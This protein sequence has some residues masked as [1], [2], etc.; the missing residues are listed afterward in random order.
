MMLRT[1]FRLVLVAA[2]ALNAAA[3]MAADAMDAGVVKALHEFFELSQK[4]QKSLMFYIQGQQV[5]GV[6]TRVVGEA[7][8]EIRNRTNERIFIRLDRIDAVAL[9]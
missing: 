6:V 3:S 7:G 4:N 9:F 8:V 1:I 2:F 5:G